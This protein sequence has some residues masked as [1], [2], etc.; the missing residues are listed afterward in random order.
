MSTAAVTAPDTRPIIAEIT[1]LEIMDALGAAH[2]YTVGAENI[3]DHQL[4]WVPNGGGPTINLGKLGT[5][6]LTI[7]AVDNSVAR[8]EA[9]DIP[10]LVAAGV[11]AA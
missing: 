2:G 10:A 5:I 11:A 7:T 3:T 4:Q 1:D 8:P 9:Q 6:R